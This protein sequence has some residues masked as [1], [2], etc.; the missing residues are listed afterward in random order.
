M[1]GLNTNLRVCKVNAQHLMFL[2]RIQIQNNIIIYYG[3]SMVIFTGLKRTL[4]YTVFINAF[5]QYSVNSSSLSGLFI[6]LFLETRLF[7]FGLPKCLSKSVL[8]KKICFST[9]FTQKQ[10]KKFPK[11]KERLM[12]LHILLQELINVTKG[13]CIFGCFSFHCNWEK[14]S[15]I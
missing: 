1:N 6:R 14:I 10:R 8:R 15:E 13:S 5:N 12:S 11:Q 2:Y 4:S 9:R 3:K 7:S